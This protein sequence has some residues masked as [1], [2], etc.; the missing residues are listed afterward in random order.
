[1][2]SHDHLTLPMAR[3]VLFLSFSLSQGEPH[4]QWYLFHAVALLRP[5]WRVSDEDRRALEHL[6]SVIV[7]LAKRG[8]HLSFR[9]TESISSELGKQITLFAEVLAHGPHP[10]RHFVHRFGKE[11]V[12]V[13]PSTDVGEHLLC[14][15]LG[16]FLS[17]DYHF[18][19][20]GSGRPRPLAADHPSAPQHDP[21]H[22]FFCQYVLLRQRCGCAVFDELFEEMAQ[23]LSQRNALVSELFKLPCVA[24]AITEL[25][26]CHNAHH[27]KQRVPPLFS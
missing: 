16:G 24:S 6:S 12:V 4:L 25:I 1:M 10:T 8:V 18:L 22:S 23:V 14:H 11:L 21:M 27:P 13:P 19:C 15:L 20:Q 5:Q 26:A 3:H 9:D 2:P 17:R 7:S